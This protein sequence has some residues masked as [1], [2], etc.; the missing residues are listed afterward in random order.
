MHFAIVVDPARVV[1]GLLRGG[2]KAVGL[3]TKPGCTRYAGSGG[4]RAMASV[5]IGDP[6][7]SLPKNRWRRTG[8]WLSWP[9][10]SRTRRIDRPTTDVEIRRLIRGVSRESQL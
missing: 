8:F 6:T 3:N 4:Y 7:L 1:Q 5:T 10:E 9:W 2:R